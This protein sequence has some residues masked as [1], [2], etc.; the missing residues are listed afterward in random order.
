MLI[1]NCNRLRPQYLLLLR[2]HLLLLHRRHLLLLHLLHLLEGR[3]HPRDG[4]R[5]PDPLGRAG[6]VPG[7]V[8]LPD[9]LGNSTRN[10]RA[11]GGSGGRVGG[12]APVKHTHRKYAK[13][14]I[15]KYIFL[16]S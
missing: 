8:Q 14:K 6:S 16:T 3:V 11:G 12:S 2:H 5:P 15:K 10:C 1:K 9:R 7:L 4:V 13:L